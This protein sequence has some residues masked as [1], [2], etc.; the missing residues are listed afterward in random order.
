MPKK[1]SF[2]SY[3]VELDE[4]IKKLND[5]EVELDIAIKE[6]KRGMTLINKCNKELEKARKEL[7]IINEVSSE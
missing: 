5:E 4:I 2:E 6:Y 3:L 7:E 1:N